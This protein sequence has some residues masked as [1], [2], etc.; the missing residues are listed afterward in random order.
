MVNKSFDTAG[1]Y[2]AELVV[3]NAIGCQSV[4]V[5]TIN[6]VDSSLFEIRNSGACAGEELT[7]FLDNIDFQSPPD[8]II[9]DVGNGYFRDTGSLSISFTYP[10]A[11]TLDVEVKT[12]TISGCQ[13][14]KAD[15]L[16]VS[17]SLSV[18]FRYSGGCANELINFKNQSQGDQNANY[19]W[20]FA[21]LATSNQE[22]PSFL[23]PDSGKFIVTLEVATSFCSET[24]SQVLSVDNPQR[25]SIAAQKK[26]LGDST[27]FYID[28]G[29]K[30][31]FEYTWN[32]NSF[33]LSGD[34][35]QASFTEEGLKP[36]TLFVESPNSCVSTIDTL[37]NIGN[38]DSIEA[39]FTYL[40]QRLPAEVQILL[41]TSNKQD[42]L[43]LAPIPFDGQHEVDTLYGQNQY[44]IRKTFA[45]AGIYSF[46]IEQKAEGCTVWDTLSIPIS[47]DRPTD[48]A[49]TKL[50]LE[51]IE[52]NLYE[53]RAEAQN[54]STQATPFQIRL[55]AAGLSQTLPQD[56]LLEGNA[57]DTYILMD[58]LNSTLMQANGICA[59]LRVRTPYRDQDTSNNRLCL[60]ETAEVVLG[61]P[62]PNPTNGALFLP[63]YVS[64][65]QSIALHIFDVTGRQVRQNEKQFLPGNHSWEIPVHAME[66]GIYILQIH[67]THYTKIFKVEVLGP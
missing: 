29:N 21:G 38:P 43:L 41:E 49:L 40:D 19:F 59:Q 4:L 64:S 28:K 42:S 53:L 66:Q 63:V 45:Q 57:L 65:P 61:N 14:T 13:V 12:T 67:T 56:Y 7:L 18:G 26:C 30:P 24:I 44:D 27:L 55:Q 15:S 36:I 10:Q 20:D 2:I 32:I 34:S 50:Y 31:G 54:L 16:I 51:P 37:I 6:I 3:Q 11:D 5:D 8:S 33:S 47:T 25:V 39:R 23:F 17:D 62:Y 60:D 48:L 1:S 9:W 58:D 52:N 46:S 35:V 22:N